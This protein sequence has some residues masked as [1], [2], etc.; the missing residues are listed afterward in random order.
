LQPQRFGSYFTT[1]HK[2]YDSRK[3]A[4]EILFH[5]L[6]CGTIVHTKISTSEIA[7]ANLYKQLVAHGSDPLAVA[8]TFMVAAFTIY[9]ANLSPESY[10]EVISTIFATSDRFVNN[11]NKLLH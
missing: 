10:T 11:S 6:G 8:A 7:I 1:L 5:N 9:A 2:N 4:V 3:T